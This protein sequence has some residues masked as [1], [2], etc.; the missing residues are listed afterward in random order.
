M[1]TLSLWLGEARWLN[2]KKSAAPD[3]VQIFYSLKT[4]L[5][6]DQSYAPSSVFFTYV[7]QQ[8]WCST[9]GD[10]ILLAVQRKSKCDNKHYTSP[11]PVLGPQAVIWVP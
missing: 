10:S 7:L 1:D 6:V 9:K 3:K 5:H 2:G 8:M 4:L 11:A